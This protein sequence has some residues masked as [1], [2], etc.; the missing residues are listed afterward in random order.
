MVNGCPRLTMSLSVLIS[1]VWW[2]LL[3]SGIMKS[4]FFLL[5]PVVWE[6]TECVWGCELPAVGPWATFWDTETADQVFLHSDVLPRLWDFLFSNSRGLH[7]EL[8]SSGVELPLLI[9]DIIKCTAALVPCSRGSN[10]W[11]SPCF[12]FV[13]WLN[14]SCPPIPCAE[15]SLTFASKSHLSAS[16]A[17]CCFSDSSQTSIP[18]FDC[19]AFLCSLLCKLSSLNL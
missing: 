1:S 16:A 9:P 12:S 4:H 3:F 15:D 11:S 2:F 6:G 7:S 18:A 13:V 17:S 8:C 5:R 14:S 19:C 10:T